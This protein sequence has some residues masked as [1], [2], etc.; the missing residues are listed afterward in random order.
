MVIGEYRVRGYSTVTD[1]PMTEVRWY[2]G[3]INPVYR[4]CKEAEME[5]KNER[6][7]CVPD[8]A[9]YTKINYI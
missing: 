8:V 4:P 6:E 2:D 3:D 1:S 9:L 7:L 5:R